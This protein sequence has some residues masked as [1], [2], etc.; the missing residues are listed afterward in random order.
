MSTGPT[1][2]QSANAAVA[3]TLSKVATDA[4]AAFASLS[5]QAKAD[6]LQLLVAAE[7]AEKVDLAAVRALFNL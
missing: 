1:A 3:A 2:T 5:G 6:F 7:A 4:K